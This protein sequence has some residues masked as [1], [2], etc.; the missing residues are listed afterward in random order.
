MGNLDTPYRSFFLSS[1]F[2]FKEMTTKFNKDLYTKMKA[3]K[4]EPLSSI[5]QKR[6]KITD[7]E[8]KK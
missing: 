3:K 5:G 4:N 8:K 1:F 2:F 6:L 7:K